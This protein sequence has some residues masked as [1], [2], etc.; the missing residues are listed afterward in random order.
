MHTSMH[1]SIIHYRKIYTLENLT[2]KLS[3]KD[4]DAEHSKYFM[5]Y[6]YFTQIISI[7][8]IYLTRKN[9]YY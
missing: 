1:T 9:I 3:T 4:S 6:H 8:L 5:N 7:S 2:K